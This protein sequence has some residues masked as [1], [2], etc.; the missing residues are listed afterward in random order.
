[1]IIKSVKAWAIKDSRNETTIEVSVN[2]CKASSPS[3]KSTG[4][5]ES[6]PYHK[7][8]EWNLKFLN[9]WNELIE[10][11]AFDDLK[12]IEKFIVKKAGL[13]DAKEFGANALFAFESAILKALAKEERK[14][15][16]QVVNEKAKKFPTPVGNVIGG[17]LHSS[18]KDRPEFQEFLLIPEGKTFKKK[19]KIMQSAHKEIKKI[20]KSKK[21]N[22]EGAWETSLYNEQ[23]LGILEGIDDVQIGI[24]VASSSFFKNGKYSYGKRVLSRRHQID[25]I[26]SL[27]EKFGVFY[28]EDPL[29]EEDFSGFSMVKKEGLVVG[30]DLTASHLS[31]TKK[32]LK[33]KSINAMIIKPN[34]NGSLLEI[35]ELFK[36][37]KKNGVKTVMSHRSGETMDNALADYAFAFGADFIK[38]GV[39]TKWRESKLKRMCEI[40]RKVSN[41]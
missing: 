31:R 7:N 24:D 29:D 38:T 28:L 26:N 2:G 14:E 19:F 23:V 39:S 35:S 11:S 8:I 9:S 15:L 5:Y 10:V 13:K 27:I 34:Q 6:K 16:W 3:G 18:N 1:M 41:K 40:E 30:D 12:K 21:K 36:F 4:K 33:M 17:G 22:D 37:C 32:A 25:Y 20:I